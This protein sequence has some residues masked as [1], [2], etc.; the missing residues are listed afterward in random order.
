MKAPS[1]LAA[2]IVVLCGCSMLSDRR[3]MTSLSYPAIGAKDGAAELFVL[4][5][6]PPSLGNRN[7]ATLMPGEHRID[8]ICPGWV[9][10]DNGNVTYV[11]LSPGAH[12]EV[13]CNRS[14]EIIFRRTKRTGQLEK[15]VANWIN[16]AEAPTF[17]SALAD[18]NG[19]ATLDAVVLLTDQ[20]YCGSGG[21][22]MAVFE[23]KGTDFRLV[24]SST[25]T[26]EPIFV[27]DSSRFGWRSLAV[28]SS[29]G[30][31]PTRQALL[32]FDGSRYPS[33][34]SLQATASDAD[35]TNASRLS[36]K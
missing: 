32:E 21:C 14:G 18:L 4:D 27:L 31:G 29:G 7:P 3:E 16:S 5:G 6:D 24:S 13:Y 10:T 8:Y 28:R 35:L 1:F 17:R 9:V 36:L 12:Y 26:R 33:N 25:I 23:G 2:T 22:R 15:A 30:G 20:R 11:R 34:P 19:D